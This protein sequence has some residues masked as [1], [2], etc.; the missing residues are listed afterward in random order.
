MT[1]LKVNADSKKKKPFTPVDNPVEQLEQVKDLGAGMVREVSS[2]PNQILDTAFEQIGL[3]P[4]RKPLSGE[5]ELSTG[6]H[7]V[8]DQINKIE[9]K[10]SAVDGKLRQLQ[11]VQRNE[12][13]VFNSKQRVLE[14][15]ISK[16]MQELQ[17]EVVKLQQQTSQL[18]TDVK[19]V[20]VETRPSNAGL[21][22]LNF[23]D[24]ILLMLREIRKSVSESRMWLN[25][26]TKKKKQKGY[27]SMFK[28]HGQNFAMSDERAIASANG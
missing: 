12:K 16:L 20:T 6:A 14:S 1:P 4:Q 19:K 18:S 27:W 22:H 21:Y 11:S 17:V 26:W 3:K 24:Q 7:K 28:K 15:Q 23:F 9:Q 8:N 25:M 5:I 10:D 13:E 2:I